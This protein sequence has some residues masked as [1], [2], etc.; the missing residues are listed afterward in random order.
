MDRFGVIVDRCACCLIH[1]NFLLLAQLSRADALKLLF[2]QDN[3]ENIVANT[4]QTD[5]LRTP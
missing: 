2:P 3:E 1:N 4:V 5:E